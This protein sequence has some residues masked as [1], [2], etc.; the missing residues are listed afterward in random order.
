MYLEALVDVAVVEWDQ[1]EERQEVFVL[2]R[3]KLHAL[4]QVGFLKTICKQRFVHEIAKMNYRQI[5]IFTM[6]QFRI[7]NNV[8]VEFK[9][10]P[11]YFFKIFLRLPK[12]HL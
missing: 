3:Q 9:G 4:V 8:C 1:L 11:S 6:K 5:L 12:K 7:E 2:L 10:I